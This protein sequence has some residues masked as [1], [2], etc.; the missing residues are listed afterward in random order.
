[1]QLL[2]YSGMLFRV[3]QRNDCRGMAAAGPIRACGAWIMVF[4]LLDSPILKPKGGV[5]II[6]RKI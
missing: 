3:Q 6:Y 5:L 4:V 2:N 1:M